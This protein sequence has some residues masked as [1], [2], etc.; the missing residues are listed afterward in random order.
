VQNKLHYAV[1]GHTAS[2]I[3]F[4]RANAELPFMGLTA[5]RGRSYISELQKLM[6]NKG[7][8]TVVH[9]RRR[10]PWRLNF[11]PC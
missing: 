5:F 4:D 10:S 3:I 1:S 11:S 7:Q 6:R 9:C 2:E 8:T